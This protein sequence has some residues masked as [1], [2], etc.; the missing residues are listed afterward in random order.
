MTSMMNMMMK[1]MSGGKG[2]GFKGGGKG[3]SKPGKPKTGKKG[4][5]DPP[6]SG[7]VFVRGFDRTTTD[8]QLEEHCSSVGQVVKV[9][10]VNKGNAIVVYKT[11]GQAKKAVDM[12]DKST[13]DGNSRYI[14]VTERESIYV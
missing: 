10:W 5:A 8:E 2:K 1:M 11:K 6:N 14:T 9:F 7:R 13:I 4:E 3:S 12:L